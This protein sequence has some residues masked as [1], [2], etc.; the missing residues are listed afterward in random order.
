MDKI[1]QTPLIKRSL[2]N[3]TE[4]PHLGLILLIV[5]LFGMPTLCWVRNL[6]AALNQTSSLA[7]LG[8]YSETGEMFQKFD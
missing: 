3:Q 4:K 2:L 8:D 6:N 5:F 1:T 7:S